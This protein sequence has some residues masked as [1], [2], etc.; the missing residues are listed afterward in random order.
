M[1]L[2][3]AIES[4]IKSKLNIIIIIIIIIII[5]CKS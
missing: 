2:L 3:I 1:Y 4:L 5:F